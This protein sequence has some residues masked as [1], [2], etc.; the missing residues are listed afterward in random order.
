VHVQA[1][2]NAIVLQ[3][4]MAAATRSADT[5]R[6]V[7][8]SIIGRI[9][10]TR[11][12][13]RHTIVGAKSVAASRRRITGGQ[14]VAEM[15][16]V[17]R[18]ALKRKPFGMVILRSHFPA[19]TSVAVRVRQRAYDRAGDAHR[20]DAEHWYWRIALGPR[21]VAFSSAASSPTNTDGE[22]RRDGGLAAGAG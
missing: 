15:A 20:K 13:T 14:V 5:S 17:I 18:A 19:D 8:E 16:T 10:G 9:V 4:R 2:A 21:T 22:R 12:R 3:F 7:D 11:T 1:T 6:R